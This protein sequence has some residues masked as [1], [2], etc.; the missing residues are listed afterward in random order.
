[1]SFICNLD[2]SNTL[3]YIES[4]NRKSKKAKGKPKRFKVPANRPPVRVNFLK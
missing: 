1:M 2:I 3:F 4:L